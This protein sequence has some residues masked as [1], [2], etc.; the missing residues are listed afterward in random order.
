MNNLNVV[1]KYKD[2]T[3]E[4]LREMDKLRYT[5]DRLKDESCTDEL[6]IQNLENAL[7]NAGEREIQYIQRLNDLQLLAD[8][9]YP[10][11]SNSQFTDKELVIIRNAMHPDK[12]QGKYSDLAAKLNSMI[13]R[14]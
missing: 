10:K 6:T 13:K 1:K 9:K 12:H 11:F 14:N 7:R 4:L 2:T 8:G 3:A 5:V